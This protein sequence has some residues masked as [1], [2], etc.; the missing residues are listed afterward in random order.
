MIKKGAKEQFSI[1]A[2]VSKYVNCIEEIINIDKLLDFLN[3]IH[4]NGDIHEVINEIIIQS[5][6]EFNYQED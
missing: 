3:E 4:L 1:T 5:K 2:V 6:V